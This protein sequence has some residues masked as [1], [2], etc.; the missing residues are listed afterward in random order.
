M[1]RTALVVIAAVLLASGIV[2][3]ATVAP[4]ARDDAVPRPVVR[5]SAERIAADPLLSRLVWLGVAPPVDG[6]PRIQAL[7][8]APSLRFPDGVSY[9]KAIRR[10]FDS[11]ATEGRLPREATLGPPL[12]LGRTVQPFGEAGGGIAIDLRSPRGYRLPDG[13]VPTMLRPAAGWSAE[14]TALRQAEAAELGVQVPLGGVVVVPALA[15]C[16]IL[17]SARLTEVCELAPPLK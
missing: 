12:P 17:D 11:L 16:Q 6:P 9:A 1:G 5:A 14:E 4:W 8:P 2:V 10:L 13:V 15:P 7:S 3:A